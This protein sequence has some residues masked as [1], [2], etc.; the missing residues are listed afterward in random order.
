MNRP[1]RRRGRRPARREDSGIALVVVLMT[2]III[3]LMLLAA[4]AY[5]TND[6]QPSRTDADSKAATAAAQ[7]G[8]DD[9]IAR[10]TAN[11]SYWTNNN[12]DPLNAALSSGQTI[13]GSGAKFSYQVLNMATIK[14]TGTI[15]LLVT[16]TVTSPSGATVSKKLFATLRVS[17]FLN[18]IYLSDYEVQDPSI[19]GDASCADY[20]YANTTAGAKRRAGNCS[21]Y[22]IQ[23]GGNDTISGP[24]HS[25]DALQINGGTD[26]TNRQTE[27]SW[28]AIT[29][30]T[31]GKTW[32]GT[33]ASGSLPGFI[34][35]YA[36]AISLPSS[37]TSLLN[38]VAP[39]MTGNASLTTGPGC[40]YA[41]PTEIIFQGASMRIRSP[42]T[43]AA[44]TPASCYNVATPSSWQTIAPIPD[45]IYVGESSGSG[46][47]GTNAGISYPMTGETNTGT[48]SAVSWG[49]AINYSCFRG[50]AYVQGTAN[51]ST[52]VAS[53]DDVVVT[54][55]VTVPSLSGNTAIGLI[56]GNAVWVYHPINNVAAFDPA[57]TIN[58]SILALNHSFLVENWKTGPVLGTLNITGAIAQKYRGPVGTSSNGV[59]V[60]GY[61]KNY[62]YDTR[63]QTLQPPYFLQPTVSPWQLKAMAAA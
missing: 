42:Q 55:D 62:L 25:N 58:A 9:Y 60:S 39:N 45:V 19:S 17:G 38:Y 12:V 4:L 35:L 6:L 37:N 13:S 50:T 61:S 21:S 48:P 41:G 8:I 59:A 30:M 28:P 46:C 44:N 3:S 63:L 27:S 52:T 5:T 11:S 47:S 36:P 7:A 2:M 26:F 29:G 1:T 57:N 22:E 20:Y 51:T 53:A 24:F 16:G 32:W 54:G 43:T 56:G 34:P 23:W 31:S 40:Y 14:S 18:Y 33:A 10:L 15:K 49:T